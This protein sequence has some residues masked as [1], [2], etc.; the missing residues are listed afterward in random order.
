MDGGQAAVV[1]VAQV[2][3]AAPVVVAVV[4]AQVIGI[5]MDM[6]VIPIMI[7]MTITTQIKTKIMIIAV[8]AAV[9]V[10]VAV[11][12]GMEIIKILLIMII[13]TTTTK[14]T[15]IIMDNMYTIKDLIGK[16]HHHP[17]HRHLHHR[18]H[19]HHLHGMVMNHMM[20]QSLGI[21]KIRILYHIISIQYR[22]I[23]NANFQFNNEN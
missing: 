17:L 4:P 9:V 8:V 15:M 11:L 10:L 19:H 20:V 23:S 16:N 7:T 1:Q 5:L 22:L 14:I 13:V 2:V 3:Q 18:P 21:T 12:I 6:E